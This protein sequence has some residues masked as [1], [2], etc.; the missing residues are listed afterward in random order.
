MPEPL[1]NAQSLRVIGQN[2][3]ANSIDS[4]ELAKWGDDYVVWLEVTDARI[5][6][7]G[8][9]GFFSRITHRILR[10]HDSTGDLPK[11]QR[12]YFTLSEIVS[13]DTERRLGRQSSVGPADQ[14]GISFV[15]RVLGDYLDRKRVNQFTISRSKNSIVIDYNQK[16]EN[17]TSQNVYDLA[18]G[19]YLRR[20]ARNHRK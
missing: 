11:R 13:A 18:I 17:F 4:F 16:Q 7:L 2:L 1:S 19:M 10:R 8:E 15:L 6:P 20:A 14:L 3:E 12:L 9:E 5:R